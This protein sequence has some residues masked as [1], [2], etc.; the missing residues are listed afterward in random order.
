MTDI[1][2]QRVDASNDVPGLHRDHV[3]QAQATALVVALT[4][5]T[6]PADA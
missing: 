1:P 5:A 6:E 4:N 3:A 2:V